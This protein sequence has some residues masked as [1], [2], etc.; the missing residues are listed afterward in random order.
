M[1][2][3]IVESWNSTISANDDVFILG[4]FCFGTESEI[5][6]LLLRLNGRK[7]LILGNHDKT[8]IKSQHLLNMFSTVSRDREI[9]VR[10]GED[11]YDITLN[12][13]AQLVWNKSHHGALHFWGHSHGGIA[14]HTQGCDVGVDAMNYVPVSFKEILQKLSKNQNYP[15]CYFPALKGEH[16]VSRNNKD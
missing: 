2:W 9:C 7:H 8:I 4:D 1:D 3:K 14:G 6:N 11:S 5:E 13:Y 12:H 16:H 10:L 15:D